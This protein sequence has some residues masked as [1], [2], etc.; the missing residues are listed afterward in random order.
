M[1]NIQLMMPHMKGNG[2][3]AKSK[4]K[5]RSS[6]RAVVFLKVISRMI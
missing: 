1:E 4:V 5:G 3:K 6:S 2:F